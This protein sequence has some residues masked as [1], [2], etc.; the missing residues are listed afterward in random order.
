MTKNYK[1]AYKYIN[2]IND[3]CDRYRNYLRECKL[4]KIAADPE[5]AFS[6]FTQIHNDIDSC[7]RIINSFY[8]EDE[9]I[10]GL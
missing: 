7:L 3:L 1:R 6:Y 10:E 9:D 5:E 8:K 4:G 2:L